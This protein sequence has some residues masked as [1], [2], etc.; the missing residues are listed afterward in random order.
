[1]GDRAK[2]F[3]KRARERA[4][5]AEEK[6]QERFDSIMETPNQKKTSIT[7]SPDWIETS[8][9]GIVGMRKASILDMLR[10]EVE[11]KSSTRRDQLQKK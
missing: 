8:T 1:M 3:M 9:T 11:T 10:G 2:D 6:Y 7:A 4:A 5:K